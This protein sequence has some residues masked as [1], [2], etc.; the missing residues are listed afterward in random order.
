MPSKYY[1]DRYGFIELHSN[2][3]R[4]NKSMINKMI[5]KKIIDHNFIN[6]DNG[7]FTINP[8]FEFRYMSNIFDFEMTKCRCGL[9][10]INR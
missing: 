6:I 5:D 9:F 2:R 10:K 7:E 3:F 4:F 8:Y 1:Y